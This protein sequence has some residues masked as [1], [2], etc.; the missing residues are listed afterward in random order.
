MSVRDKSGLEHGGI[1]CAECRRDVDEFTAIAEKWGYWSD[2]VGDLVP[3]CPECGKREFAP[4]APAS[5]VPQGEH[6]RRA[7]P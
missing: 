5:R 2:G 6:R 4:D 1:R 3:F 7:A